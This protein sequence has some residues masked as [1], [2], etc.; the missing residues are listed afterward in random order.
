M[1]IKNKKAKNYLAGA[2]AGVNNIGVILRFPEGKRVSTCLFVAT[3]TVFAV[4]VFGVSTFAGFRTSSCSCLL[5]SFKS[6]ML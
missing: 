2:G 1:Y 4:F 3:K 5:F 6:S